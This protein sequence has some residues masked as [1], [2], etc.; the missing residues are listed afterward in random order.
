MFRNTASDTD[1]L[2]WGPWR[3]T[4]LGRGLHS[5]H[6]L[7]GSP[8]LQPDPEKTRS[9]CSPHSTAACYDQFELV[10]H[11]VQD[12]VSLC[13]LLNTTTP[14]FVQVDA[15]F[16]NSAESAEASFLRQNCSDLNKVHLSVSGKVLFQPTIFLN[17]QQPK[18]SDAVRTMTFSPVLLVCGG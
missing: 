10:T 6:L 1:K 2:P 7:S 8:F 5:N 4:D 3:S 15:G 14:A 13:K 12:E 9:E 16:V 18:L 11:V 17:G